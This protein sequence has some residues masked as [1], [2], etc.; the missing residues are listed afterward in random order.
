VTLEYVRADVLRNV[1]GRIIERYGGISG[2]RDK[3]G[4]ES[5]IARPRNLAFYAQDTSVGALGAALAWALLRNHP[6]ADGN[7]R[8]AFAGL[9]MFLELNGYRL[10]CSEVEETAMVMRAAA[11]D[12]TEE[13]WTGWVERRVAPAL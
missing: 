1:H 3:N 7:K 2:V 4:L 6:F 10:T 5:A 9:T 12:I 11:S 13:E 8:A